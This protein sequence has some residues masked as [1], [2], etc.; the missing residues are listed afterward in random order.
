MAQAI[1][2]DKAWRE[3]NTIAE[4][5]RSHGDGSWAE[6]K[7][8]RAELDFGNEL[9]P[10]TASGALS[11]GGIGLDWAIRSTGRRERGSDRHTRKERR[12]R[13]KEGENEQEALREGRE[14]RI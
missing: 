3:A 9:T 11:K 4:P 6:T 2:S 14:F 8:A 12:E 13:K 10:N 7:M 1:Q 5:R